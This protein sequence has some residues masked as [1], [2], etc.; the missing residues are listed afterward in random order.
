[1]P[2]REEVGERRALRDND[3]ADLAA[4]SHALEHNQQMS[5]DQ[6]FHLLSTG[7]KQR[8]TVPRNLQS[9]TASMGTANTT[10]QNATS[11]NGTVVLP[12]RPKQ[13]E[14][15][16]Q[17]STMVS[18]GLFNNGQQQQQQ[19]S[20]KMATRDMVLWSNGYNEGASSPRAWDTLS[21][22]VSA[23]ADPGPMGPSKSPGTPLDTSLPPADMAIWAQPASQTAPTGFRPPVMEGSSYQL[24]LPS[25]IRYN[26]HIAPIKMELQ[27]MLGVRINR[28]GNNT[29]EIAL[30]EDQGIRL[31]P[32]SS[33]FRQ[34]DNLWKAYEL[35]LLYFQNILDTGEID[36]LCTFL[37]NQMAL[38]QKGR[39]EWCKE[40]ARRIL[41]PFDDAQ[42][43]RMLQLKPHPSIS[44]DHPYLTPS[45]SRERREEREW[46]PIR[47]RRTRR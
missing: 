30:Y 27:S 19:Q 31:N 40:N 21:S 4:M 15:Q 17:S 14:Q 8:L 24:N 16:Q 13:N 26:E 22:I 34:Y 9:T 29:L 23:P 3:V 20:S 41:D 11:E 32:M 43:S 7:G 1:M 28:F 36:D 46:G 47:R 6:Y 25:M 42:N 12:S 45:N 10:V 18:S 38:E 35:L 44:R 2:T 5:M 39:A 37:Q 33:K